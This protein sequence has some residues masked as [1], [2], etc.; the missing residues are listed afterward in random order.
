[1]ARKYD[2]FDTKDQLL[3]AF[4]SASPEDR[5]RLEKTVSLLH[6]VA[7]GSRDVF[8]RYLAS[9]PEDILSRAW[10]QTDAQRFPVVKE[11]MS[12]DFSEPPPPEPS[13]FQP[14]EDPWE[15]H[16]MRPVTAEELLAFTRSLLEAQFRRSDLLTDPNLTKD[17]LMAQFATRQYEVFASVFLDTLHRVLAFDRYRPDEEAR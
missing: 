17:F 10:S 3:A 5:S 9:M 14:S 16:V 6:E 11:Q 12:L 8:L 15:Y 4:D 13:L 7:L 2:A 1:V